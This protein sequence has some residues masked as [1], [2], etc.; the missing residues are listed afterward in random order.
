MQLS[1]NETVKNK[2]P[3]HNKWKQNKMLLL[4][5]CC[6]AVVL[7]IG[8]DT[9]LYARNYAF[10]ITEIRETQKSFSGV[11]TKIS[12]GDTI[13]IQSNNKIIKVRLTEVDCPEKAQ[14]YGLEASA[15][16]RKLILHQTVTVKIKGRDR[17]KRILGEVIFPD[18]RSLNRL[19]V[20]HGWAWWYR[21]YSQDGSL[22]LL[23][24]N[25]RER[26]LGLWQEN[27]P[28]PPWEFRRMKRKAK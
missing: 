5:R 19:L 15:F 18:G 6:F 9:L 22:G 11:V 4:T 20:Q 3:T 10:Q 26:N 14:A 12:D 28:T 27:N 24:R 13:K 16:V 1:E 17:Y 7:C 21:K 23:E 25:A 2:K 8:A